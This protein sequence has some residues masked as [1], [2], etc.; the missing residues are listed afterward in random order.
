MRPAS[1]LTDCPFADLV[2]VQLEEI[3]PDRVVGVLHPEGKHETPVS[4][5]HGGV[6]CTLVETLSSFGAGATAGRI[7]R[8]LGIHTHFLR[9]PRPGSLRAAAAPLHRGSRFQIWEVPIWDVTD[10]IVAKGTC[11]L[12]M[13][14]GQLPPGDD[15]L[16][17]TIGGK[18]PQALSVGREVISRFSPFDDLVGLQVDQLLR[19]RISAI[20]VITD[21]HRQGSQPVDPGVYCTLVETLATMG[22][23]QTVVPE[24]RYPAGME[25]HTRLLCSAQPRLLRAV[26]KPLQRHRAWHLWEVRICDQGDR[27]VAIGT[28]S[29]AVTEVRAGPSAGQ[30]E[31]R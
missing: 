19:D 4:P 30:A 15:G 18:L 7:P 31:G 26:A 1:S 22:A 29:L 5:V 10:R 28:C 2:G 23:V 11:H 9:R 12:S 16:A 27:L 20:L 21:R 13:S 25:N 14:D 6:Y 8:V 3:T 24:G 17:G